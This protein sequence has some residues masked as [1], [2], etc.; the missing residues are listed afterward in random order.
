V[1]Y[2]EKGE[3]IGIATKDAGISKDGTEKDGFTSGIELIAKQ[4]LFAEGARGSCSEEVIEKYNLRL[5]M[6]IY[7]IYTFIYVYIS[8]R[9]CHHPVEF[10]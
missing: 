3:I 10:S 7:C 2:G 1:L 6:Y 4:T 5:Y 8:S 9:L